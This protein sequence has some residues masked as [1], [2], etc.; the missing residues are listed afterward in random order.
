MNDADA[1]PIP[2]G[3]YQSLTIIPGRLGT[4][5]KPMD[6]PETKTCLMIAA[7]DHVGHLGGKGLQALEEAVPNIRVPIGI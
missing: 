2:L 1:F 5:P 6:H 7:G 3:P 4:L